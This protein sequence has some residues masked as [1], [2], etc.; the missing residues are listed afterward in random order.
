MEQTHFFQ[1]L[2]QKKKKENFKTKCFII[3][4]EKLR[5]IRKY[6]YYDSYLN[7]TNSKKTF[8]DNMSILKV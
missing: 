8:L 6:K 7:Q 4:N 2:K 5:D 3:K 1:H